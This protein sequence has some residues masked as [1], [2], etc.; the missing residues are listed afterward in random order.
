MALMCVD[1]QLNMYALDHDSQCFLKITQFS[2]KTG[3]TYHHALCFYAVHKH[4]SL[5]VHPECIKS[6]AESCKDVN[7]ARGFQFNDEAKRSE[8]LMISA[9]E[10]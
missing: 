8:P 6:I 4:F 10:R 3:A 7:D 5:I 9:G 2:G 1:L